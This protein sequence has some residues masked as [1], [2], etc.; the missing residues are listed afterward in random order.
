MFSPGYW[1]DDFRNKKGESLQTCIEKYD[2]TT[3]SYTSGD[4]GEIRVHTTF[5]IY[6]DERQTA[7]YSWLFSAWVDGNWCDVRAHEEDNVP[8]VIYNFEHFVR[9]SV[10]KNAAGEILGDQ[11][12]AA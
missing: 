8:V 11:I 10:V 1:S 3:E 7:E 9:V 12:Q 5:L 4:H 6:L 2:Y